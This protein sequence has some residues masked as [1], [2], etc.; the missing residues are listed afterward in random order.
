MDGLN[1]LYLNQSFNGNKFQWFYGKISSH[2][3]FSITV[4]N[5]FSLIVGYIFLG[6][7]YNNIS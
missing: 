5:S 6:D 4:Y 7:R 2:T 3:R 1:A